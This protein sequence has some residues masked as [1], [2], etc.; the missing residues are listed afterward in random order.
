MILCSLDVAKE[1]NNSYVHP[2][3]DKVQNKI[4]FFVYLN[5]YEKEKQ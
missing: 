2:I 4:V 1:Q 5:L 3:E